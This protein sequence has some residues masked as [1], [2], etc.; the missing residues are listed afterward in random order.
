MFLKLHMIFLLNNFLGK[1]QINNLI[2]NYTETTIGLKYC[3]RVPNNLPFF[4]VFSSLE[5]TLD[6][7]AMKDSVWFAAETL[8]YS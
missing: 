5:R 3:Y 4:Q 7:S 1:E 8:G 2:N 6:P